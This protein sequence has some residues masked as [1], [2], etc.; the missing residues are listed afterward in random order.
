MSNEMDPVNKATATV[1][2]QFMR[3]FAEVRDFRRMV[4][5]E[6]RRG[7]AL[8]AAAFLDERLKPLLNASFVDR[9]GKFLL[10]GPNAPLGTFSARILAAQGLG[11]IPTK[12]ALDL[13]LIRKIRNEFAHCLDCDSFE[14]PKIKS[15]CGHLHYCF[16]NPQG[17]P[18]SR[19]TNAT[20][21]ILALIDAKTAFATRPSPSED[22]F[23]EDVSGVFP[24]AERL[25]QDSSRTVEKAK[26]PR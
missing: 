3:R 13:N 25:E 19:F 14:I 11:L 10:N 2:E 24:E 18:R 12:A 22:F 7:C 26:R 6:S 4:D 5:Y 23:R 9:C 20:S 17:S 1:V 21:G 8:A 15:L 16:S